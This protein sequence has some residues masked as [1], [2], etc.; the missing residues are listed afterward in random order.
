MKTIRIGGARFGV[1]FALVAFAWPLCAAQ[2]VVPAGSVWK[3]L[4]NYDDPGTAWREPGFNDSAWLAGPAKLGYGEGDEAT[5]V[6][7][8]PNPAG[9]PVTTYFRKAFDLADASTVSNVVLRVR[10]DD[11]VIVYLNGVEIFRSNMPPGPVN[12]VTLAAALALD[13]GRDWFSGAV[14]AG[15]LAAGRNVLAAEVHQVNITS[16]DL[17]FDLEL[18]GEGLMSRPFPNL[19]FRLA[20]YDSNR[21]WPGSLFFRDYTLDGAVDGGRLL[22]AMRVTPDAAKHYYYGTDGPG[23]RQATRV[24][25]Q[26]GGAGGF[27]FTPIEEDQGWE[28]GVTF[29]SAR[30]RMALATLGGEG[31]LYALP[32]NAS[33]WTRIASMD[34]FDVDCLEYHAPSDALYGVKINH[35]GSGEFVLYEFNPT[36]GLRREI[37][38]PE[39]PFDIAPGM[40]RSELVSVGDYLV[41][42][43]EPDSRSVF[44][45]SSR[46]SRIY[47]IDPRTGQTWLTHEE[48]L[49]DPPMVYM[50]GPV[51]PPFFT[52][53]ASIRLA[54]LARGDETNITLVEFASD[55]TVIGSVAATNTMQQEFSFD[56]NVVTPGNYLV[57]ARAT[58]ARGRTSASWEQA[59]DVLYPDTDGDGVLD[60]QDECPNTLSG[61]AVNAHGCSIADLVPCEGAWHNHAEYVANVILRAWQFYRQGQISAAQRRQIIIEAALS[62]CGRRERVHLHLQ[63]QTPEEMEAQ[64]HE[65]IV[66]GAEAQSYVLEFSTNLLDWT[67]VATNST[68][69]LQCREATEAPARFYRARLLP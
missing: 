4:H 30:Q 16:S 67:A 53:P 3:Y 18:S 9:N 6:G 50:T 11:G 34:N 62:D 61:N 60:D 54:A 45:S 42:L 22:P 23:G 17:S 48:L 8:G 40:H 2:V 59:I 33:E 64:G 63:P 14:P 20:F 55:G 46:L 35:V 39:F 21:A 28:M 68:C 15:L 13:D 29:D 51:N 37:S 57:K 52:A 10:R 44:G 65:F 7:I 36:G 47:V 43:A 26:T 66:S 41:L 5:V 27:I 38:L 1:L 31:F 32:N 12:Y 49:Y 24:D 58:D 69:I 56:W 25:A 19:E